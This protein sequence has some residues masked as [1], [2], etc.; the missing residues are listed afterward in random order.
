MN[1]M[2][3]EQAQ[4]RLRE[5]EAQL[6]LNYIAFSKQYYELRRRERFIRRLFNNAKETV[7]ELFQLRKITEDG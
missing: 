7:R 6:R 4:D 5:V 1:Q 2:D 3:E